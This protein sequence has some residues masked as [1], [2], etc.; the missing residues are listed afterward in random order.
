MAAAPGPEP[1]NQV[2]GII[3]PKPRPENLGSRFDSTRLDS[4]KF[5]NR[6]TT[7]APPFGGATLTAKGFIELALFL[8]RGHPL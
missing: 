3:S 7:N 1:E 6:K 5:E 2:T 4:T 8:D